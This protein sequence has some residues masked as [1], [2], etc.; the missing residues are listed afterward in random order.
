MRV[1]LRAL[2]NLYVH[3]GIFIKESLPLTLLLL[4]DNIYIGLFPKVSVRQMPVE[5][6]LRYLDFIMLQM[7]Y[8]VTNCS[9]FKRFAFYW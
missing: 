2:C 1:L 5:V 3:I 6:L 7:S 8:I 4:L 9:S